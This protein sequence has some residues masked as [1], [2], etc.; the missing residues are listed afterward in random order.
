MTGLPGGRI[1]AVLIPTCPHHRRLRFAIARL[2]GNG[3]IDRVFGRRGIV[4]VPLDHACSMPPDT[5]RDGSVAHVLVQN[6]A[7]PVVFWNI[8]QTEC[9]NRCFR[10]F[11]ELDRIRLRVQSR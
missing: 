1:L 7:Q 6:G 8:N 2:K 4:A 9:P 11:V 3:R 5:T 10:T